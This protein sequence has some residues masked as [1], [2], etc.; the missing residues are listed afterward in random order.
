MRMGEMATHKAEP[1]LSAEVHSSLELSKERWRGAEQA[2]DLTFG[3]MLSGIEFFDFIAKYAAENP[4]FAFGRVAE[5]G[6]GYGRL[7]SHGFSIGADFAQYRGF[8][9]SAS[10]VEALNRAF[11]SSTVDFVLADIMAQDFGGPFET[12]LCSSTFEHFYPSCAPVLDRIKREM[13]PGGV[14][15]IDFPSVEDDVSV[16]AA[17]FAQESGEYVRCYSKAEILDLCDAAGLVGE[18]FEPVCFR[19]TTVPTLGEGERNLGSL[20]LSKA[21]EAVG[22]RRFMIAARHKAPDEARI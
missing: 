1:F 20:V 7:Y 13:A 15:F 3:M 10:R 22:V 18:R 6:P 9:I 21:D 4:S 5:I 8:D 11:G 17:N 16:S 2:H 12:L 14:A 19:S